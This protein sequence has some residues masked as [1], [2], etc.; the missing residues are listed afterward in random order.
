MTRNFFF[1]S[2]LFS[3]HIPSLFSQLYTRKTTT[4]LGDFPLEAIH[5][6]FIA[7]QLR[8]STFLPLHYYYYYSRFY[9]N[10]F[11]NNGTHDN[12]KLRFPVR[13]EF[14]TVN[15][16]CTASAAKLVRIKEP[17][18]CG[19]RS[20]GI[21]WRR[22]RRG[23]GINWKCLVDVC[24][25]NSLDSLRGL[26]SSLLLCS[27][28]ASLGARIAFIR[29]VSIEIRGPVRIGY[30]ILYTLADRQTER[31]ENPRWKT[32]TDSAIKRARSNN[33][34]TIFYYFV[35]RTTSTLKSL[36]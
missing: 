17:L 7:L 34:I 27:A 1:L 3:P 5:T 14:E 21:T 16:C 30:C 26:K 10:L 36:I 28:L 25:R 6:H 29:V 33:R 8:R 35:I 23:G 9:I 19:G 24:V 15:V 18:C 11:I 4:L 2:F 31:R 13:C 12:N 22:R 32:W 20:C